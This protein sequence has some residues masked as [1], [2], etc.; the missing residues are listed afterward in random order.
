[1]LDY[2]Q[3]GNNNPYTSYGNNNSSTNY[4]DYLP[5]IFQEEDNVDW[6]AGEDV[7]SSDYSNDYSGDMS[8]Q[9]EVAAF[10]EASRNANN[11]TTKE[12][13]E[14][15]TEEPSEFEYDINEMDYETALRQARNILQPQFEKAREETLG[16]L[17][18]EQVSRGF[19]GQA[20]AD[21]VQQSAMADL[22]NQ[23]MGT[24]AS[25]AQNI[26]QSD[27]ARKL[28]QA[29][30]EANLEQQEW[31]RE[32]VEYQQEE[33]ENQD[34]LGSVGT[35][36]AVGANFGPWGAVIGGGLGLLAGVLF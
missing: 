4:W 23:Y 21:Y 5:D 7:T 35:G 14:K 15:T 17:S 16:N 33:Q 32:Q 1:M 22:T 13:T 34:L 26:Q 29:Q 36:A 3:S 25:Q 24:L 11:I 9:E 19:Y 31:E 30:F 28:Q 20:P 27:F 2:G 6:G 12:T 10:S 18:H 8:Y